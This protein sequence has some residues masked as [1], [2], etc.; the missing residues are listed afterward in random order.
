MSIEEVTS[1]NRSYTIL[2][3]TEIVQ[4][5]L[6]AGVLQAL[7]GDDSLGPLLVNHPDVD[8]ISFTGSTSAGKKIMSDAAKTM[9]RVTLE[10]YV[11]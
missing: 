1:E 9:K 8:K 7:S 6:P 5:V 11:Y 3:A 2:K 10:L 4:Q